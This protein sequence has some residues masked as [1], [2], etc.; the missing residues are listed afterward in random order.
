MADL[1]V[2]ESVALHN[3]SQESLFSFDSSEEVDIEVSVGCN[4]SQ[5]YPFSFDASGTQNSSFRCGFVTDRYVSA[6]SHIVSQD[7]I[8]SLDSSDE[9]DL[10]VSVV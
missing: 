9:M 3:E 2:D 8:F 10:G 5:E 1:P 6:V 7:S 4:E